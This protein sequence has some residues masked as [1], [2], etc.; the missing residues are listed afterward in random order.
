M[1]CQLPLPGSAC[2]S[3]ALST[4]PFEPGLDDAEFLELNQRAFVHHPDQ[5]ALDAAGLA[6]RMAAPWFSPDGF[7]LHESADGR[8]DGFCWT[9]A[10]P[11]RAH[12]PA[13][14]EIY[15]IAA[16]PDAQGK[17][18]GRALVCAGLAHLA[19]TGLSVGMLYVESTNQP[20]L[21]LYESL[22]FELHHS[23]A[24]YAT[25]ETSTAP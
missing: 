4:R 7:L 11:Q 9:K 25:S 6:Q 10:H 13:M 3:P 19:A 23:D 1:R 20:A 5:G 14:G 2:G 24:G 15:V 16:D 21:S 12:D 17:G 8:I 22:G 18:L